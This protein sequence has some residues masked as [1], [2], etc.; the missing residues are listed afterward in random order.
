MIGRV[1]RRLGR[2]VVLVGRLDVREAQAFWA[3]VHRPAVLVLVFGPPLERARVDAAAE[4]LHRGAAPV[5]LR[6]V[7][8][9]AP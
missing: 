6:L 3:H 7:P 5:L 9:R 2:D 4:V 8:E 1:A